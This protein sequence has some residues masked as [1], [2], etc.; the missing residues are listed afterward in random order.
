MIYGGVPSNLVVSRNH[1]AGCCGITSYVSR[2]WMG[3]VKKYKQ[4]L[5]Q[6][7]DVHNRRGVL[8]ELTLVD[9]QVTPHIKS[10]LKKKGF[11]RVSRF[12][13]GNSGN[14]VNVYHYHPSFMGD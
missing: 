4:D 5:D 12:K 6:I 13:N 3:S 14:I 11:R 10:H 9:K 2:C 8:A 7:V 1:G